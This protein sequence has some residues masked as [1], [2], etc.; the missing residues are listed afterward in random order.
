M[1]NNI[2]VYKYN[3]ILLLLGLSL[4][5][6]GFYSSSVDYTQTEKI[7]T[8]FKNTL[9]DYVLYTRVPRGLIISVKEEVLFNECEPKLNLCACDFLNLFIKVLNTIPN[10]CVIENHTN[11]EDI[12]DN[13]SNWELSAVRS[14]KI[15]EYFLKHNIPKDRIFEIGFGEKMPFYK[16]VSPENIIFDNRIDFVIIN[17]EAKR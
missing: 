12:K 7:E 10:D 1:I 5:T 13:L 16:N 8:M 3:S 2:N 6:S 17:Y 11:C 4:V 14:A 9:P 15:S